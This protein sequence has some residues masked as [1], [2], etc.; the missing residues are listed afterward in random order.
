MHKREL[1]LSG[2]E[3]CAVDFGCMGLSH[4]LGP[5]ADRQD[6][7]AVIRAVEHGVTLTA[8]VY[9]PYVEEDL[10]GQALARSATAAGSIEVHGERYPEHLQRLVDR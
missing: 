8:E 10:V 6:G 5:A 3:V 4:G 2:V 1:D 9:G 7:I